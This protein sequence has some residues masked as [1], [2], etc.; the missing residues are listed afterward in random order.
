MFA[1]WEQLQNK[2][3]YISINPRKY[4]IKS[5]DTVRVK[6]ICK[7]SNNTRRHSYSVSPSG[8][9]SPIISGK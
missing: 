1:S 7:I 2:F 5:T 6:Q 9:L 4:E 8:I 3:K